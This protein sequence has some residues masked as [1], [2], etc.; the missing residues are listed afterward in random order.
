MGG[1]GGERVS[2]IKTR[3]LVK[4]GERAAKGCSSP[5]PFPTLILFIL[6]PN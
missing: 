1:G 6:T 4:G 5:Y 2:D 3:E